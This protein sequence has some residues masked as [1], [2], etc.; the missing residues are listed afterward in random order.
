[1]EKW[2]VD[3]MRA[4]TML[5]FAIALAVL[6]GPA[7]AVAGEVGHLAPF[8]FNP[9]P[10]SP[11]AVQEETAELYRSQLQ[12]DEI[13]LDRAQQQGDPWAARE[14][15]ETRSELQRMERMLHEAR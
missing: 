11:T 10:E 14:L 15:S 12:R 4:A 3:V 9:P 6:P 2:E 5:H 1:L 8:R 13:D 7:A